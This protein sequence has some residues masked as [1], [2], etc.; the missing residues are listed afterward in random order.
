MPVPLLALAVRVALVAAKVLAKKAPKVIPKVRTAPSSV[1]RA[2]VA[3]PTKSISEADRVKKA[4]S[5]RVMTTTDAN[6]AKAIR[7]TGKT[8]TDRLKARKPLKLK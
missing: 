7:A 3:K 8:S 6:L 1:G 5:G 4:T 2:K